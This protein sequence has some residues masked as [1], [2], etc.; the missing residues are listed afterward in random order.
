MSNDSDRFSKDSIDFS[1]GNEDVA[2]IHTDIDMEEISEKDNPREALLEEMEEHGLEV[3][4]A[5]VIGIFRDEF[6][7]LLQENTKIILNGEQI[8]PRDDD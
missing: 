7:L 5:Q 4:N 6:S 8:Y 2:F 3:E 1:R